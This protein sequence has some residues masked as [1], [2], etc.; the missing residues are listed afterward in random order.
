VIEKTCSGKDQRSCSFTLRLDLVER[1]PG[2]LGELLN[3]QLIFHSCGSWRWQAEC[4]PV[5]TVAHEDSG[6]TYSADGVFLYRSTFHAVER[7]TIT[8]GDV[9][10]VEFDRGHFHF[11]GDC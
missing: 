10:R 7:F 1:E 5:N 6:N 4:Q 9:T 3:C 2:G 8:K 11:F